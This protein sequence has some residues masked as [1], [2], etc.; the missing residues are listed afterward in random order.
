MPEFEEELSMSLLTGFV[1]NS[2]SSPVK[3]QPEL[4][5]NDKGKNKKVLFFDLDNL[6][7]NTYI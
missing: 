5:L 2:T 1:N 4:L 6:Y 7:L 3:Y